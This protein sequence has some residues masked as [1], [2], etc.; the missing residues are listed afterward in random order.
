MDRPNYDREEA[1][2]PDIGFLLS[3]PVSEIDSLNLRYL[4]GNPHCTLSHRERSVNPLYRFIHESRKEQVNRIN[5]MHEV[6][7][8]STTYLESA[9]RLKSSQ[10]EDY[11]RVSQVYPLNF[12]YFFKFLN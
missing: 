12:Y 5:Q 11:T 10:S 8:A 4:P 3:K 2:Y 7:M 9:A 1:Y 6:C